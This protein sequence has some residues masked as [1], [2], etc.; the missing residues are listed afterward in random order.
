[1]TQIRS[2]AFHAPDTADLHNQRFVSVIR[3]GVYAG[4][5]ARV[6]G[7]RTDQ[8]DITLGND[9]SSVLITSQG[10]RIEETNELIAAAQ[11]GSVHPSLIRKDLLVAEYTFTNDNTVSATYKIISGRTQPSSAVSAV[12]PALQNVFQVEIATIIV[13]AQSSRTPIIA[14]TDII[15]ASRGGETIA[16]EGM[17]ALKPEVDPND[18]TRLFVQ[19]GVFP[20][21][22][23]T[24]TL[25]FE[26]G[27]S[28]PIPTTDFTASGEKRFFQ[29][30]LS[31][32]LE[33]QQVG[34]SS[35][36]FDDLPD[37][38]T[39]VLPIAVVEAQFNGSTAIIVG[40]TDTRFP[41]T[42]LQNPVAE[43]VKY[44]SQLGNSIFLN[45][46]TESFEDETKIDLTTVTPT[47]STLEVTVNKADSSLQLRTT[48]GLAPSADVE[49]VTENL[50]GGVVPINSVDFLQV[51]VDSD[52]PG[53]KY[54]FS[55]AAKTG[56]FSALLDFDTIQR[57]SLSATSAL[58]AT[59]L[60]IKFVIPAAAF[61]SGATLKIRSY[62]VFMNLDSNQINTAS[63]VA[64]G[65]E[66]LQLSVPNLIANGDFRFWNRADIN[67]NVPDINAPD[68]IDYTYSVEPGDIANRRS[69]FAADGWQFTRRGYAADNNLVSRVIV[70]STVDNATD[71]ALLFLG[72]AAAGT[73]ETNELEYRVDVQSEWLGRE[74]TFAVDYLVDNTPDFALAIVFYERDSAGNL[75]QQSRTDAGVTSPSGTASVVANQKISASTF[76]VGFVLVLRQAT[77]ANSFQIQKARA[78]VGRFIDLPYT[79]P[80]N[81]ADIVRRYYEAGVALLATTI[82]AGVQVATSN[83]LGSVKATGLSDGTTEPGKVRAQTR[84][85]Q[86]RSVN[87]QSVSIASDGQSVR[88][89]G[90][91]SQ[92]APARIDLDWE[93][94][95][96][97]AETEV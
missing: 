76:A 61:A 12:K 26:G 44:E 31:D 30:A 19:A 7:G 43:S 22:E 3:A 79:R 17:T 51:S 66:A 5:K 97:Y 29:Y 35:S 95:V 11:I 75:I 25:Q 77:S 68:Q 54:A 47:D 9:P 2:V 88:I 82:E 15:H 8:L 85:G 39:S 24:A 46:R 10:I 86:D 59:A 42:R 87:V 14:N 34:V 41:F 18:N 21:F 1:M 67:G 27:Y 74:V 48:D 16:P 83:Q 94:E 6:N 57:A 45:L 37:I 53:L 92:T 84:E 28:D 55:P 80:V 73:P 65:F 52:I 50:I 58:E 23:G 71:T 78:A 49:V 62:G 20:N 36:T 81:A 72:Q 60:F 91:A 70:S 96:V 89:E 38:E 40:V 56:P 32:A 4:Y 90:V 93:V 69:G 64:Q 13:R 33:V 63:I